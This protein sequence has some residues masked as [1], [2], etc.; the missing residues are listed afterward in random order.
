MGKTRIQIARP[1]IIRYFDELP[2]K[3]LHHADLARILR[4]QRAFWRLTLTTNTAEFV[5]FL[6]GSGKLSAFEFPFHPPYKKKTVYAWGRVPFYEIVLGISGKCY[7][8]HYSAVKI[9]GLTEQT[10][11]TFYINEEQRL[12]SWLAGRLTQI[13]IDAAFK[14]PVRVTK[15][16]AK[17]G[18]Y[19]VVFLNGKNTRNLG[20]VEQHFEGTAGDLFGRLR[21][22]NI[23]RT[24]ID[25]TV[26]P[27]YSGG[28]AE[29]LKAFALAREQVSVNRLAVMFQQL[30]FI[31]P[32]HQ[33][34]GFYLE[35]ADYR[36][37]SIDLFRRM[38]RE[39]DFYLEHGMRE[40]EYVKEWR[41]FIPKGF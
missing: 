25:V 37:M 5:R 4:E 23:E 30:K 6:T 11:K 26:R 33:A 24:L 7:F 13:T 35:R 29:V 18:E 20:V 8:S 19:R 17:T 36:P 21:V 15:K 39:F 12:E 40:K 9:H 2:S 3:V 14:R 16:V 22:T 34:I 32:Y 27:V 28:V 10:P 38:P 41:L 31:Y 1:D